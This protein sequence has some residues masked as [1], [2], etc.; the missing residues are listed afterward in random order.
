MSTLL[1][2]KAL[3]TSGT[4]SS[5]AEPNAAQYS[6]NLSFI[7]GSTALLRYC[8]NRFTVDVNALSSSWN[9][10]SIAEM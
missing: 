7:S 10:S 4:S 9:C 2:W 6:L 8:V 3:R 5:I 1:S